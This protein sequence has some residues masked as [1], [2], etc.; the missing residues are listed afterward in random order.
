MR[1]L[2]VAGEAPTNR[3]HVAT[4]LDALAKAGDDAVL[5]IGASMPGPYAYE[6][7]TKLGRMINGFLWGALRM[8]AQP[9]Q[10]QRLVLGRASRRHVGPEQRGVDHA[11]P[12]KPGVLAV[13]PRR[14]HRRDAKPRVDQAPRRAVGAA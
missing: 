1:A 8:G 7:R 3:Q 2:V 6:A 9:L 13:A 14:H 11:I 12:P 10:S 5:V 4:V